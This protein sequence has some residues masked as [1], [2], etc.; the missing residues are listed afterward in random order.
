M[1]SALLL[2]SDF[3]KK[4]KARLRQ[5]LCIVSVDASEDDRCST[6]SVAT[7]TLICSLAQVARMQEKIKKK[8]KKGEGNG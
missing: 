8:K 7:H 4:K 6:A 3:A 1:S 5:F 2:H